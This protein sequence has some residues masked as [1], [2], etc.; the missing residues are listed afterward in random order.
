[1]K[2]TIITVSMLL[3]FCVFANG[4]IHYQS[5][6]H[7]GHH[8]W[9]GWSNT[10]PVEKSIA[11]NSELKSYC[12]VLKTKDRGWNVPITKFP[13][14][15]ITDRTLIQ[16]K[17][18]S[19]ISRDNNEITFF[20]QS[21][22]NSYQIPFSTIKNQWVAVRKYIYKATFKSGRKKDSD[23]MLGDLV[24]GF[25]LATMGNCIE[26]A[27][28]RIFE[29]TGNE[30]ELPVDQTEKL[31]RDY[32]SRPLC[33]YPALRRNGL[34]PYG[35]VIMVRANKHSAELFNRA[36]MES[37]LEDLIDMRRHYMNTYINF[38]ESTDLAKRLKMI[39]DAKINLIET[40]FC[41]T[42][43]AKLVPGSKIDREFQMA[44]TSPAIIAWYGRDEPTSSFLAEYLESKRALADLD[45]QR[46][47][48]SALHLPAIRK[49]IGP[50]L[51]VMIPDIYNFYPS[52]PTDGSVIRP[53]YEAIRRCREQAGGK[54]IWYMP[55][56][57]SN[58][59]YRNNKFFYSA[60]YPR[61]EEIRQELYTAV[62]AGASGIL[63]FCYNDLVTYLDGKKRGEEFDWTL[64]DQWGNGNPVYDEIA[65]FGR[66]I[67]PIMPSFL[68]AEPGN[69]LSPSSPLP[70]VLL[71]GQFKNKYGI[72][73][74][75]VNQTTEKEFSGTLSFP[76]DAEKKQYD[77]VTLKEINGKDLDLRPGEGTLRLI[78]TSENF[79]VI[80]EEIR[81]RRINTEQELRDLRLQELRNAGFFNG[82]ATPEWRKAES[83]LLKIRQQ[84]GT[85]NRY[86]TQPEIIQEAEQSP[87]YK[88]LHTE[89]LQLSRQYFSFLHNL[90]KGEVPGN[91]DLIKLSWE[92][93]DLAK[94]YQQ[95]A[96]A[97][98]PAKTAE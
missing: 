1:M 29:G 2:K 3:S 33:D 30:T 60:R 51:E 14:F 48:V 46:P 55:Q 35:A 90:K 11:Y 71:L 96:S 42:N 32:L 92:L 54:R 8:G 78:A 84:F 22:N 95:I 49:K 62:A 80:A 75:V 41:G 63:F 56:T 25:Q 45:P 23:G 79:A 26:L 72:L 81:N 39:Q 16:F 44:K 34:F 98:I 28:V 37:Y 76:L 91:D 10:S 74:V 86:L 64:V 43:F 94:R 85:L 50:A 61:P 89:L 58:R 19:K 47:L 69:Y 6:F 18:R 83:E 59:H 70:N 73:L 38:W 7:Q 36:L 40:I 15:T 93:N 21:E 24:N 27:D 5:N 97:N 82:E 68:D 66:K 57:F 53:H 67:V 20:N 31:V 12:L 65:E 4:K 9:G 87:D 77:L 88:L 52:T 13:S 17:I